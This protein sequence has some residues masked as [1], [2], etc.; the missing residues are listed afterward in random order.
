MRPLSR[1]GNFLLL[2]VYWEFFCL[3]VFSHEWILNFIQYFFWIKYGC[4]CYF[5]FYSAY[6]LNYNHLC[7]CKCFIKYSWLQC[8]DG[9]RCAAYICIYGLRKQLMC[10]YSYI[11][12]FLRFFSTIGSY[13]ALTIVLYAIQ[14]D[15]VVYLFVYS[16]MYLLIPSS[17]FIPSCFSP[18]VAMILFSLSVNLFLFYK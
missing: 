9:F 12:S 2:Q 6:V 8:C 16:S 10:I 4:L 7:F 13:R 18:L 1:W 15:L 5:S 17:L 11:Y 3:F 14:Q